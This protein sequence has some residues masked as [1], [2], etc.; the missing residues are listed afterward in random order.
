MLQFTPTVAAKVREWD[1]AISI[2]SPHGKP[3]SE[4]VVLSE[5]DGAFSLMYEADD[6]A[7]YG[8]Y[9]R[10]AGGE[11]PPAPNYLLTVQDGMIVSCDCEDCDGRKRLCKH[12]VWLALLSD[13]GIPSPSRQFLTQPA[14]I[15]T[16]KTGEAAGGDMVARRIA[17]RLSGLVD[18][19]KRPAARPRPAIVPS[20]D[21]D[22]SDF[23]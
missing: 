22:V 9:K 4:R 14:V 16:A 7:V 6:E 23:K 8:Y 18:T 10:K 13:F 12:G 17:P 19:M 21:L 2:Q 5:D 20:T 3:L 15:A 1:K 11:L